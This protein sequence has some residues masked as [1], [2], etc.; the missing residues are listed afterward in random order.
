MKRTHSLSRILL[1]AVLSFAFTI[2][3]KSQSLSTYERE[4]EF[5]PQLVGHE[6]TILNVYD[7]NYG[8]D[9]KKFY[10]EEI[11]T[12]WF[13]NG[14]KAKKPKIDKHFR[15]DN[16][17]RYPKTKEEIVGRTFIIQDIRSKER[18]KSSYS[19]EEFY[20]LT[21]V[22]TVMNKVTYMEFVKNERCYFLKFSVRNKEELNQLKGKTFV[23]KQTGK[24]SIVK[25]CYYIFED[26]GGYDWSRPSLTIEFESGKKTKH[27]SCYLTVEE[28][29][30]LKEEEALKELERKATSGEYKMVLNKVVK[31]K[32]SKFIVG[33][34]ACNKYTK[35][36]IYRDNYV[37]FIMTPGEKSFAFDLT[38]NSNSTLTINWDDII[39]INE[40]S[41]SQRVVHSGIKYKDVSSPQQS[42]LIAKKSS[43]N[44]ALV[45]AKNIHW[46]SWSK[47]WD[48]YSLL[49]W[50]RT[51]GR[52]D[53]K[54]VRLIFPI[55]VNGVSYEYTFIFDLIWEWEHP[56]EREK[57]LQ[58]QEENKQNVN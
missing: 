46:S 52:Y 48:V 54:Q 58:L 51:H 15:M 21:L 36:V 44:D 50:S 29:T 10:T 20:V 19:T 18:Q 12:I 39:Y 14:R 6:I 49:N 7:S 9:L 57:W 5:G 34:S 28:Y 30:K 41:E 17:R 3:A 31:P 2:C 16:V 37:S 43:I 38:N 8:S 40:E 23:E 27:A 47:E 53:G 25:D 24:R 1:L 11:D 32:S 22:D 13:K 55:Q 56:K 35:T 33:E 4:I 42:S 45:P 26:I